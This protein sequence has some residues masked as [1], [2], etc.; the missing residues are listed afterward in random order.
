MLQEP[1]DSSARLPMRFPILFFPAARR[2]MRML[3]AAVIPMPR[4]AASGPSR[5]NKERME[6]TTM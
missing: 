4:G 6:A 1:S 5:A 3:E 2:G